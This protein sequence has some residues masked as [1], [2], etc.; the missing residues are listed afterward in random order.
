MYLWHFIPNE[1]LAAAEDFC[2]VWYFSIKIKANLPEC[3]YTTNSRFYKKKLY[4]VQPKF[5]YPLEFQLVKEELNLQCSRHRP[6]PLFLLLLIHLKLKMGLTLPWSKQ[7]EKG[8]HYVFS[9]HTYCHPLPVRNT[10]TSDLLS[11]SNF[12]FVLR[13][14]LWV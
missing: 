2:S 10:E 7:V 8:M 4:M 3:L 12:S 5:S 1:N 9:L 14:R 13:I 11:R 6:E